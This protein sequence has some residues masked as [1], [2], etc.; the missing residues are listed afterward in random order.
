MDDQHG[1]SVYNTAFREEYRCKHGSSSSLERAGEVRKACCGSGNLSGDMTRLAEPEMRE[2]QVKQSDH[3]VETR[4]S[5]VAIEQCSL[6]R[7]SNSSSSAVRSRKVS[8]GKRGDCAL[9]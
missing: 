3:R 5:V 2:F 8:D 6:C 9:V 7:V 1:V 4:R